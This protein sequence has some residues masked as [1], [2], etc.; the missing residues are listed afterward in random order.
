MFSTKK[1]IILA[2]RKTRAQ[3]FFLNK[4]FNNFKKS[5]TMNLQKLNLTE[6]NAQEMNEITGGSWIGRVFNSVV[7]AVVDAAEWVYNNFEIIVGVGIGPSP[8]NRPQ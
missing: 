6:L 3:K 5:N 4:N 1:F 2:P 7:N 8:D